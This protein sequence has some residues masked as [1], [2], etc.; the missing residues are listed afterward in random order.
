MIDWLAS[1]LQR[2][3]YRLS[4]ATTLG[5]ER[6]ALEGYA[7]QECAAS[8]AI[9]LATGNDEPVLAAQRVIDVLSEVLEEEEPEGVA[10]LGPLREELAALR[11][12]GREPGLLSQWLERVAGDHERLVPHFQQQAELDL[13]ERVYVNRELRPERRLTLETGGGARG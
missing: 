7:S 11:T 1:V 2:R 4:I 13:L 12:A 6:T 8:A 3:T 9:V 5:L 10:A